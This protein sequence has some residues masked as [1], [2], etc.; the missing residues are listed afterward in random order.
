M[1]RY[2]PVIAYTTDGHRMPL[3]SLLPNPKGKWVHVDDIH[4]QFT[5]E[6][7]Q[8]IAAACEVAKH[9]ISIPN[10]SPSW[11]VRLAAK[12]RSMAEGAE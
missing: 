5:P 3:A 9:E 4:V 11:W 1:R 6:E 10:H 12:A 7:L 8:W 2:I